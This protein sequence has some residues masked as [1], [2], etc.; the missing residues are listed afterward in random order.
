[1]DFRYDPPTIYIPSPTHPIP[2]KI[3][4]PLGHIFAICCSLSPLLYQSFSIRLLNPAESPTSSEMLSGSD[5]P[6]DLSEAC[7]NLISQLGKLRITG[8]GW[9][10]KASFLDFYRSKI[11]KS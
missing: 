2:S 1:M 6:K 7:A 4:N 5:D 11:D 3:L 9:E 8:L 10:D